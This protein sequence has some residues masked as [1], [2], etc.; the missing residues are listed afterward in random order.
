MKNLWEKEELENIEAEKF[1]EASRIEEEQF[2]FPS[3]VLVIK[4]IRVEN[5][6][7]I[8]EGDNGIKNN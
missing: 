6:T 4:N 7:L 8:L 2:Q 3:G 5:E 1:I